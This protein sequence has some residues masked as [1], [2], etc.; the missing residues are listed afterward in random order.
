MGPVGAVTAVKVVQRAAP[1]G[2]YSTVGSGSMPS[3]EPHRQVGGAPIQRNAEDYGGQR[4]LSIGHA[5]SR[6]PHA[7]LMA[8][9]IVPMSLFS[10][11]VS[12]HFHD[13]Q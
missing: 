1:T 12:I 3:T 11:V 5:G 8:K 6:P 7:P 9:A 4:E 10:S 13:V 2:S